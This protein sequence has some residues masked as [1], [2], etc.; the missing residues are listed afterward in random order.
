VI[1]CL[2][3]CTSMT[4]PSSPHTVNSSLAKVDKLRHLRS[5]AYSAAQVLLN[6]EQIWYGGAELIYIAA[7][8]KVP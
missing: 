1:F 2:V 5:Y 4:A 7:L 6:K 3:T 8:T